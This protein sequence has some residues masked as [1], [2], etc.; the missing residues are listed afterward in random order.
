MDGL[1]ALARRVAN[2][3]PAAGEIG[4]GMLAQLVAEARRLVP[5]VVTHAVVYAAGAHAHRF[6]ANADALWIAPPSWPQRLATVLGNEQPFELV[7][8]DE[9]GALYRQPLTGI[10]LRVVR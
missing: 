3:N 8:V 2:L 6:H 5:A 4:A 1:L 7:Q 10:R 9:F